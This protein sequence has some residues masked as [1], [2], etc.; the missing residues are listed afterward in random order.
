MT[1]PGGYKPAD[2]VGNTDFTRATVVIIGA[3]ISG[4]TFFTSRL[5]E[6]GSADENRSVHG[7]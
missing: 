4:I 3:G 7:D 6:R 1:N 5:K 2:H